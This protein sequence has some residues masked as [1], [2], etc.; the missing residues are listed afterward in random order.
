MSAPQTEGHR[1]LDGKSASTWA[2]WFKVAPENF[3]YNQGLETISNLY[4]LYKEDCKRMNE[5]N[6][7]SLRTSIAWTRLLPDKKIGQR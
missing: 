3:N 2:Y 5:L 1:S 6:L 4:A 7:N